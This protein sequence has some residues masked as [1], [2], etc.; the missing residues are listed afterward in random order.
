MP[1]VTIA[2]AGVT[3]TARSSGTVLDAAL[4]AGV[5]FPH[6]CRSGSCGTCKSRVIAGRVEMADGYDPAILDPTEVAAG[7]IL[8]CRAKPRSDVTVEWLADSEADTDAAVAHPVRRLKAKVVD[9]EPATHALTRLRLEVVGRPLAFSAGQYAELSFGRGPFRAYSMAN[10]PDETPL[11]FHI[12]HLPGGVASGYVIRDL[13]VGEAVS[14]KGPYGT[15]YLRGEHDAAIV[16]VA[17]G[18]GLAPI[19]SIVATALARGLRRPIHLYFGVADERDIYAE[20][21]LRALEERHGNLRFV[22]VL[23]APATPTRRR[24]GW[25][26]EAVAAD[27]PDLTGAVVYLAGPP[28]MVEAARLMA[29][30]RGVRPNAIHADPFEAAVSG[31]NGV[32]SPGGGLFRA[33]AGWLRAGGRPGIGG[34]AP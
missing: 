24:T 19:K 9:I 5:P 28:P 6:G 8:C 23:S 1:Q 4:E 17:G 34:T 13:R 11:E 26:H 10:R 3:L 22:P 30:E 29:I 32:P 14:L 15:A 16:A 27:L 25:V 33:I 20:A 2:N 12:R 31:G 7:L 18:S 21:E